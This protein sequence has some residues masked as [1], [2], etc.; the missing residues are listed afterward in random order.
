MGNIYNVL[1]SLDGEE[2]GRSGRE[3]KKRGWESL[4]LPLIWIFKDYVREGEGR[5]MLT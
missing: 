2:S 1:K 4:P 5:G 3:G